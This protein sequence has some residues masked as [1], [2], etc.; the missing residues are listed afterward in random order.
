MIL[1]PGSKEPG[2]IMKECSI[3]RDT[4][5]KLEPGLSVLREALLAIDRSSLSRLERYFA[6]FSTI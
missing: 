4:I 5:G 6:I 1:V 3:K 2:L